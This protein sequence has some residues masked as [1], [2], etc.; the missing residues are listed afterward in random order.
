M[1]PAVARAPEIVYEPGSWPT[2]AHRC[3][4]DS[5]RLDRAVIVAVDPYVITTSPGCSTPTLMASAQESYVPAVTGNPAGRPVDVAASAVT[6]PT[7]SSGLPRVGRSMSG[8]IR[9]DQS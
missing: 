1:N 5:G 2:E 9:S 7:T 6:C 4:L 8:A 3:G